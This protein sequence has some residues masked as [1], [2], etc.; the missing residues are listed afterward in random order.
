MPELNKI[1]LGDALEVLRSWPDEFVDCIITSPPY[2]GLRDYGV[3][4][5][6]GLEKNLDEYLNKMLLITKELHR[7]LKRTGTMWINWGDCY[8]GNISAPNQ[9][10]LG[11]RDPYKNFTY[12]IMGKITDSIPRR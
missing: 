9:P 8:G 11:N 3:E 7:V 2:Y 1:Y 6:L 5:Q 4:E 12:F 10:K